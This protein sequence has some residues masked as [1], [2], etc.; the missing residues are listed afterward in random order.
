MIKFVNKTDYDAKIKDMEDKIPSL[1][2]SATTTA[3]IVVE[4]KIPNISTLVEKA[5]YDAK[6]KEI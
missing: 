5:D 4:N 2:N 3:L 1:T 6:I